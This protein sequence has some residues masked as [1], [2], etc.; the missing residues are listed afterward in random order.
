[1]FEYFKQKKAPDDKEMFLKFASTSETLFELIHD[2]NYNIHDTVKAYKTLANIDFDLIYKFMKCKTRKDIFSFS[3]NDL[4]KLI[5]D[6]HYFHSTLLNDVLIIII[7]LAD[8]IDDIGDN[9]N[10]NIRM[11]LNSFF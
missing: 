6:F 10:D 1:M 9:F 5:K 3:D 7:I 2:E 4:I 8:D 11:E